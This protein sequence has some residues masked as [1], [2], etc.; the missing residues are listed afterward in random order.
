MFVDFEGG[1]AQPINLLGLHKRDK[2]IA[3][4][5]CTY[6]IIGFKMPVKEALIISPATSRTRL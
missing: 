5:I 3:S 6:K 4:E 2:W 1:I